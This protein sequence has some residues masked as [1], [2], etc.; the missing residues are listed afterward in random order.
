MTRF[1]FLGQSISSLPNG[2]DTSGCYAGSWKVNSRM[3]PSCGVTARFHQSAVGRGLLYGLP[4]NS[5][6]ITSNRICSCRSLS[7]S[8]ARQ[9]LEEVFDRLPSRNMREAQGEAALLET[10]RFY[11]HFSL[12]NHLSR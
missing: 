1:L 9:G 2:S 6:T 11:F 10:E 8:G 4:A 5:V 12:G 3:T 7:T